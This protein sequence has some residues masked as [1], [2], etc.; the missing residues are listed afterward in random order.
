MS[1]SKKEEAKVIADVTAGRIPLLR[2][3]EFGLHLRALDDRGLAAVRDAWIGT[4]E[5]LVIV[6]T[7]E[8]ETEEPTRNGG[9]RI[10]AAIEVNA[11]GRSLT[12]LKIGSYGG[13][14][15]EFADNRTDALDRFRRGARYE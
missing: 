1:D 11:E 4:L 14:A 9:V 6:H 7:G 13:D 5:P 15:R 10:W 8:H 2:F 3:S 12:L